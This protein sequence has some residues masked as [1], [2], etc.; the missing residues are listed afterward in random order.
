L[1]NDGANEK[2]HLERAYQL[3]SKS[4]L[5]ANNLAW[6]LSQPPNPDFAR[7]LALIDVPLAREPNNPI[8]LD[9]RGRIY[10]AMGRWKD[11]LAD[12]EVVLAKAPDTDGLHSALAEVYDK[13]N[14]PALA[15]EHRAIATESARKQNNKQGP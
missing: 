14:Q 9:T 3:D 13:L 2:F 5:I 7:A 1:R 10:L 4:G 11:A 12:L 8:Y 15:A 6:V